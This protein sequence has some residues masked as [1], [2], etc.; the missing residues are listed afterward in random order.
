ME[1]E[2]SAVTGDFLVGNGKI[3]FGIFKESFRENGNGWMI[4]ISIINKNIQR[5]S[6]GKFSGTLLQRLKL[7]LIEHFQVV[8]SYSH[9]KK[10]YDHIVI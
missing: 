7:T 1:E 10:P 6:F 9:P 2:I 4:S 3:A 8:T 5:M